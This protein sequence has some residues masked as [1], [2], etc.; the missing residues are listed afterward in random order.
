MLVSTYPL[1]RRC[2]LLGL[3][4]LLFVRHCGGWQLADDFRSPQ[5]KAQGGE[6][7]VSI[8]SEYLL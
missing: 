6:I 3:F 5:S 2:E 7:I 4:F 8:K 1:L